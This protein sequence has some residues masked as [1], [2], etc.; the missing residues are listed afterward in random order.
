M[1]RPVQLSMAVDSQGLDSSRPV[2]GVESLAV[3]LAKTKIL[4][5]CERVGVSP[6]DYNAGAWYLG[7]HSLEVALQE[8]GLVTPKQ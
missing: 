3:R 8:L 5:E 6:A 4:S 1:A 7:T 2:G